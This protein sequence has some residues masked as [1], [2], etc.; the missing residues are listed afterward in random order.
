MGAVSASKPECE[1]C[2]V[3]TRTG[4]VEQEKSWERPNF[5]DWC[6]SI[7]GNVR[8]VGSATTMGRFSLLRPLDAIFIWTKQDLG[9]ER[10]LEE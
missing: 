10:V 8:T 3:Q 5:H 6:G 1:R 9:F 2:F 7:V 4:A